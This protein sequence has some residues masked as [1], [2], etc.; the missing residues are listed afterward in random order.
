MIH[1]RSKFEDG[2]KRLIGDTF[3]FVI[4]K[5]LQNLS[6]L[7]FRDIELIQI[8]NSDKFLFA[9]PSI[10]ILIDYWEDTQKP[11]FRIFLIDII[12]KDLNKL[13]ELDALVTILI[14]LFEDVGDLVLC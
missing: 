14:E 10:A 1:I 6:E 12:S 4:I 2:G 11:G 9:Q 3:S 5:S 7:F 8:D 13:L